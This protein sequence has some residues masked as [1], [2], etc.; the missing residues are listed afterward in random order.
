MITERVEAPMRRSRSQPQMLMFASPAAKMRVYRNPDFRPTEA[1]CSAGTS[2]HGRIAQDLLHPAAEGSLAA[3]AFQATASTI[4]AF[5]AC[6]SP[7]RC[8][9]DRPAARFGNHDV[10][11]CLGQANVVETSVWAS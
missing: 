10:V 8:A 7:I 2:A 5:C 1:A 11:V 4:P 3:Y 9:E 6:R